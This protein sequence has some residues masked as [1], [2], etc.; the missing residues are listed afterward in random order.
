MLSS[1]R[2]AVTVIE[3]FS[4]GQR[5]WSVT[6]LSRELDLPQ[7]S[8]H[9]VLAT[10]RNVGW[11]VQD[12]V[13]KRY[14]L[15]IKLWEIGCAAV[16]FREIA[17]SARPFLHALMEAC[18]ETVHL[19]MISS[20]DPATVVYIDRVDSAEPVRIVT[21]LGSR[22]PS[23]SSAMGKAILA[24]NERFENAIVAKPLTPV[25]SHT[26]TDPLLLKKDFVETRRRGYS[27]GKGEFIG[28]MVGIAV[29]VRDR[30]GEVTLGIG[31]WAPVQKMTT[32]YIDRI[33]PLMSETAQSV[34]QQ[35]GYLGG[36]L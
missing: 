9:H 23:H 12:P 19:G 6:E 25:T 18:G 3:A 33:A 30:F 20:E 21:A 13:S 17:E 2:K 15:G 22:A 31:L 27:I 24:H 34:S 14:R 1:V 8:L 10:F 28:E 16:N 7:P 11:V 35:L 32:Q 5:E 4:G 26:I 29:P 36:Q